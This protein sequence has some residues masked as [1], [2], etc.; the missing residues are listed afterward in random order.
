MGEKGGA[1]P[2][3]TALSAGCWTIPLTNQ[4][5]RKAEALALAFQGNEGRDKRT[6]WIIATP[7]TSTAAD[8][9]SAWRIVNGVMRPRSRRDKSHEQN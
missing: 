4:H 8:R 3:P 5:V 7:T 2:M 6:R 9:K 1:R